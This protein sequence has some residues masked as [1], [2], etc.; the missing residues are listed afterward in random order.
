MGNTEKFEVTKSEL[1]TIVFKS[2][3]SALAVN[4]MPGASSPI[5]ANPVGV[6]R[7]CTVTGLKKSTIYFLS[8][9]GLIPC[10]KRGKRLYFFETELIEW[11]RSGKNQSAQKRKEVSHA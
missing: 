6:D 2:V 11:I 3:M 10:Q 7:A 9:K 8:S 4:N 1:E 5:Q